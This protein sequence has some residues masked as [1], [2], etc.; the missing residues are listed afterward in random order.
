[1]RYAII[2][3]SGFIGKHVCKEACK[4]GHEIHGMDICNNSEL[5]GLK[6]YTFYNIENSQEYLCNGINQYDGVVCLAAKRSTRTF[7]EEEFLYNVR[8]TLRL[9]KQCLQYNITNIVVIS[10][11]ATY[12]DMT[13]LPWKEDQYSVPFSLYG[14]SKLTIDNLIDFYDIHYGLKIKS[15]RLAQVL[16]KGERKGYLLNT[17]IE[18]AEQRMPLEIYGSGKG[19]RQYIYVKDVVDAILN[20]LLKK[21]IKGI[22]NIGM[23]NNISVLELAKLINRVYDNN[24]NIYQY[25]ERQEDLCEYLMDVTK[26]TK[27]LGWS[28]K[29]TLESALIDMKK[30]RSYGY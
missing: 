30:E 18:R 7:G 21:D 22:F 8:L 25:K 24:G 29:Y 16:G 17:L 14:A 13:Q 19:R 12:S 9:L 2:G 27:I 5:D 23:D 10:S 26:A 1:M 6:G 15:L 11:I 20:A 3:S 28:A 4:I